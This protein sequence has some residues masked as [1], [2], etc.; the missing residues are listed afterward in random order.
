MRWNQLIGLSSVLI[1]I[2]LICVL[3]FTNDAFSESKFIYPQGDLLG[4][5]WDES[6]RLIRQDDKGKWGVW[7][8][9]KWLVEPSFEKIFY[10]DEDGLYSGIYVAYEKSIFDNAVYLLAKKSMKKIILPKDIFVRGGFSEGLIRVR[11]KE[12]RYGMIDDA[13]IIKIACTYRGLGQCKEGLIAF[14]EKKEKRFLHGFLNRLG[15]VEIPTSFLHV[16][17]FSCGVAPVHVLNGKW[18]VIGKNGCFMGEGRY[19]DMRE[20]SEGMAAAAMS[21]DGVQKWGFVNILTDKKIDFTFKTVE[22]FNEGLAAV[23]TFDNKWGFINTS[24]EWVVL[25]EYMYA[26]SFVSGYAS[27]ETENESLYLNKKGDVVFKKLSKKPH[28]LISK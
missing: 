6:G 19:E 21:F 15:E 9:G 2:Q 23:Q 10:D 4:L 8:R 25:P 16:R 26:S 20:Y 17:D 1:V 22:S 28:L 27:V 14:L 5:Y 18:R 11:N 7:S 3:C 12:V 24:G 13:G